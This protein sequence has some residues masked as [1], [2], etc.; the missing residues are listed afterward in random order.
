MALYI[1]LYHEIQKQKL[2]RQ[3]DPLKIAIMGMLV[4]AAGLIVY[5]FW[6]MESV[7]NVQQQATQVVSDLKKYDPQATEAQK[8]YDAYDQDI[9]LS[10]AIIHK[11]ENRFYWAPLLE[12]VIAVVPQDIQI[13]AVDGSVATDG[14]KKV[15]LALTGVATGGQPRA[16]AEELRVALQDKLSTA[17]YLQA[18]AIFRSLE[19]GAEPVQYM[20]KS[21][22]TVLFVIDVTFTS[23]DIDDAKNAKT[24]TRHP[25][26]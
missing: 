6:R 23:P 15:T 7:K 9:K 26:P 13:T 21:S 4:I 16:V 17:K 12:Q 2:K 14:S 25:Q 20:G 8:E 11:M 19:D 24:P 5:Y 22:P 3:R 1:N 18:N 10:D